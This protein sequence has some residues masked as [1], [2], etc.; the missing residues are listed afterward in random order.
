M[1]RHIQTTAATLARAISWPATLAHELT[2]MLVAL[3]WAVE[4]AIIVD[5][6]GP[7]HYVRWDDDTPAWAVWLASLAPTLLGSAVGLIGLLRLLTAPPATLNTWLLA[8]AIA[9]YWTIY[10]APSHDDRDINPPG[11]TNESTQ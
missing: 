6:R 2:H 10:V 3:P 1:T 8:G 11:D 4:S 5:E 7:A 9:G